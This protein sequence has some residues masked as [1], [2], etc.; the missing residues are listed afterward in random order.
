[1]DMFLGRNPPKH[2]P[3]YRTPCHSLVDWLWFDS[4]VDLTSLS[5]FEFADHVW[6]TRETYFLK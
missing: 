5:P 3:L 6:N 4:L 1:M 2:P